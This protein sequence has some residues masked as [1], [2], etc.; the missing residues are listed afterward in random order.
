M[1]TIVINVDDINQNQNIELTHY[2]SYLIVYF[3][4][5]IMFIFTVYLRT[6]HDNQKKTTS[7]VISFSISCFRTY[8][9]MR[10]KSY[11]SACFSAYPGVYSY[12]GYS[13]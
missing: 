12:T 3:V 2:I 6:K 13:H 7:K 9:L 8:I 4:L 10:A 1:I 5:E 11:D